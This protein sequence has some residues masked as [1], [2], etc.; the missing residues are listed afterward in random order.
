M[1][2]MNMN[3]TNMYFKIVMVTPELAENLLETNE[4]NRTP[5]KDKLAKIIYDIQHGSFELTHQAIAID[6]NGK[7][8]D[9][10]HRL[11]GVVNT[12]IAVPMVIAY[13]APTSANM[14]I[15]TKRTQKQ[16]LYMAGIIEKGTIE[17][18]PLTYPLISFAAYRSF[19]EERKG[20]L[21]AHNMHNLY[22]NLKEL[23][24]PI[25]S[26]GAKANGRCRSSVIL[27]AMMCAYN[28]GVDIET[29]KKW[30]KIVET[31]DFYVEGDDLMTR[32]GRSVLNFK[33]VAQTAS[34][35]VTKNTKAEIE[36]VLK[37]AMSSISHYNNGDQ[38]A[39]LYGEMVYKDIVINEMMLEKQIWG[40]ER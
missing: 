6:V 29:L 19:G 20:K 8:I 39:R 22:M 10:Q 25:I 17:Y 13:N 26:I 3:P 15:G 34:A 7:L 37:K 1:K 5:N 18:D 16:A 14:D 4:R 23:I 36:N 32:A 2:T 35:T 11:T 31:G 9:G 12:G 24:D 21:T 28:E 27:Y 33:I 38:I 30:H 40:G